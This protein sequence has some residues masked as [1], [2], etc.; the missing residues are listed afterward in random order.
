MNKYLTH[1]AASLLC[2]WL[3]ISAFAQTST[4]A[5]VTRVGTVVSPDAPSSDSITV[6]AR[7]K[8]PERQE[9][10]PEV[11]EKILRFKR[12][13]QAYLD[14]EQALEKQLHG[15]NDQERARVRAE[16]KALRE[17]WLER[18]RRS[19]EE[20]RERAREIKEKLADHREV[21]DSAQ[22]S[23]RDGHSNRDRQ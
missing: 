11:Q 15:A 21:I 22:D 17:Q 23:V 19:R 3:G 4:V 12:D 20:L 2:S 14:R 10:S 1:L 18:S 9:L 8:V 6:V 5:N 7:P 16:M 13:A